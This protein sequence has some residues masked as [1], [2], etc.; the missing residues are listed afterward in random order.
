MGAEQ[1]AELV[2]G[3]P[4]QQGHLDPEPAQ[5]DGDIRRAAAGV[6]AVSAAGGHQVDEGLA[7]DDNHL[8]PF[9]LKVRTSTVPACIETFRPRTTLAAPRPREVPWAS[10]DPTEDPP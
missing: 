3:E 6:G 10:R 7:A 9:G 2:T 4:G 1:V 5:P 8:G